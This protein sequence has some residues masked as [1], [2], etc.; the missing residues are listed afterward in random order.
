MKGLRQGAKV[1]A[2]RVPCKFKRR[3]HGL[4]DMGYLLHPILVHETFGEMLRR[5]RGKLIA[6]GLTLVPVVSLIV[7]LTK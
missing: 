1:V 3:Q 7:D 2:C 6:G 4:H 5:Q